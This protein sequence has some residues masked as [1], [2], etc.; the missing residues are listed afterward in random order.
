MIYT[1]TLNPAVDYFIHVDSFAEG[2]LNL[3]NYSNILCGG[4]GINV[5]QTLA[6]LGVASMATGFIGGETGGIILKF[7]AEKNIA[8]DF[9]AVKDNTRINIKLYNKNTS[10]ETE[11]AGISP[12]ITAAQEKSLFNKIVNVVKKD[13]ILV[14]SGSIPP[15]VSKNIYKKIAENINKQAKVVL[16]TRGSC[17][18]ENLHNNFLIKPNKAELEEMFCQKFKTTEDIIKACDYFFRGDIDNI[19]VSMGK[20]GSI[21]LNKNHV[22]KALPMEMNVKNS[23]GAG[24]SMVAGFIYGIMQGCE[25]PDCYKLAVC[26]SLATVAAPSFATLAGIEVFY[27]QVE[28]QQIK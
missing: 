5:S 25:L 6:N 13:D 28:I 2:E 22:Y 7:L 17:L 20:D 12:K 24:D 1:L 4:K 18:K 3:A 14:L 27:K 21:Y 26:T 19:I 9:M 16:D 15:S 23:V 10:V 8:A 11:I